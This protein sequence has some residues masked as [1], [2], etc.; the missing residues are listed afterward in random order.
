MTSLL[1]QTELINKQLRRTVR[2]WWADGLWD[3]AIGGFL[4][5][6]AIVALPARFC[7]CLSLPGHGPG[8]SPRKRQSIPCKRKS[9]CG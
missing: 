1:S 7:L 6:T 8:R 4:V 9:R 5:V 3:L 2:A